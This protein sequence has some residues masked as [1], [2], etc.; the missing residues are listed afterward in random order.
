[1]SGAELRA[2]LLELG[3]TQRR[4]ARLLSYDNVTVNRWAQGTA[5][6]PPAVAALLTIVMRTDL[7]IDAIEEILAD[8]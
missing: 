8:A 7:T 3:I 1:M 4:L 5:P 6:V 2:A